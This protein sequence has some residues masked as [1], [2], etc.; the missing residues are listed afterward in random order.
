ML[1]CAV[2]DDD[3]N[4]IAL[5]EFGRFI[6]IATAPKRRSADSRTVYITA[7]PSPR[8]QTDGVRLPEMMGR[9]QPTVARRPNTVG[10]V[11]ASWRDAVTMSKG[12]FWNS[13]AWAPTTEQTNYM[14]GPWAYESK[15]LKMSPRAPLPPAS[16]RS[17]SSHPSP[18]PLKADTR[19]GIPEL[20]DIYGMAESTGRWPY[21]HR[22]PGTP[23]DGLRT[24]KMSS[25][26]PRTPR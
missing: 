18:R 15:R 6:K 2:D 20:L 9:F 14:G 7:T 25:S 4:S 3:S 19:P 23:K 17:H 12:Q 13:R 8:N 10:T 1:W 21:P 24:S 5:V 11:T 16:P 26:S 22:F